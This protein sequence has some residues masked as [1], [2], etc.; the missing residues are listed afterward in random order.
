MNHW[1]GAWALTDAVT[2]LVGAD[3]SRYPSGT[4]LL[5]AGSRARVLVDP[6]L[7]VL[8]AGGPP[9][10]VDHVVLS[11][12]HED[13]IAGLS[14]VPQAEVW[15][16][17]EDRQGLESLDGL[18]DMYGM[19]PGP[20]RDHWRDTVTGEFGYTSRPDAQAFTE[21]D[22]LDLGGVTISMVHLPGHTRGHCA[23][24]ITEDH[25]P[26]VAYVGDID[27]SSFGP[28]YGDAWSSLADFE[29]S[30][31]RVAT[32]EAQWYATFHHK[33]MVQGLE[34]FAA[35]IARYREVID[36]RDL[37]LREAIT[38][39]RDL[40]SLV[41]ERFVYRPGVEL[42]FVDSVERRTISQHLDRLVARGEA[43]YRA[44]G[45]VVATN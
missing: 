24:I 41:A 32:L 18:M 19:A 44:D 28:Y 20:H 15:V 11:H 2:A 8:R 35:E 16:H 3:A 7:D 26:C 23:V 6:S 1:P 9:V 17:P 38:E 37:R 31:D 5:V 27:L 36:R 43:E 42:D 30:L 39:P 29:L 25:G 34:S 22:V 21:G 40:D 13:H 10:E 14:T 33:G 12:V 45:R 4:S